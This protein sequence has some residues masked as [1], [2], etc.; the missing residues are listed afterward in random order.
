MAHYGT[1]S[2]YRFPDKVAIE[3]VRG[4]ALYGL[5]DDKLGKIDDVI[6]DHVNGDIRYIVVDT[7]GWLSSKKFMVPVDRVYASPKHK[8]DFSVDMTKEQV[9]KFPPYDEDVVRDQHRWSQYEARYRSS[10]VGSRLGQRWSAFENRVRSERPHIVGQ[11]PSCGVTAG[12]VS[13]K[14]LEREKKVG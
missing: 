7:G 5:N 4:A 2:T 10:W 6:F 12:G 14:E 1:L 9:E 8:D 13:A 3:D 11:C